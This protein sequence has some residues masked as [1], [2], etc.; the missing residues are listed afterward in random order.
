MP[1]LTLGLEAVLEATVSSQYPLRR[2]A[3]ISGFLKAVCWSFQNHSRAFGLERRR[4]SRAFGLERR[5][6]GCDSGAEGVPHTRGH[7][8]SSSWGDLGKKVG[9]SRDESW[10]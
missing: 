8:S 3:L 6:A 9:H 4:H 1:L 10:I 7:R 2:L 5:P